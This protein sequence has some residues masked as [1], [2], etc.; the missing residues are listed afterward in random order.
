MKVNLKNKVSLFLFFWSEFYFAG[1]TDCFILVFETYICLYE[2]VFKI[3]YLLTIKY[4]VWIRNSRL[5][6]AFYVPLLINYK[7]FILLHL[8]YSLKCINQLKYS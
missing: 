5:F 6:I 7:I 8:D 4:D 1:I 2:T 3:S